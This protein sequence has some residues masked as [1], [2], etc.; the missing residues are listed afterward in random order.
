MRFP[1]PYRSKEY[2]EQTKDVQYDIEKFKDPIVVGAILHRLVEERNSTNLLFKQINAKLD[3]MVSLLEKRGVT[4]EKTGIGA[5]EFVSDVDAKILAFV[6]ECKKVCAADVK[7]EFNY[8]GMNA[9]CARLNRLS[10]SGLLSKRRA[11]RRVLYFV[12][13]GV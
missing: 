2:D 8:R 5:E 13:G 6:K 1:E 10:E 7:R 4:R 12:P 3:R 9:A 11:G